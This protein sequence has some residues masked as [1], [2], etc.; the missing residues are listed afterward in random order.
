MADEYLTAALYGMKRF[1]EWASKKVK[2]L[3]WMEKLIELLNE[4]ETPHSWI[5]FKSYD[6]YDGT[7][8]W[9]DIDG[10]TE[11]AWSDSFICG[12]RF[13]WVE[14]L[15]END[16]IDRDKNVL[17][18][19]FSSVYTYEGEDYEEHLKECKLLMLLSIQDNPIEFLVSI[20]K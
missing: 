17:A 13:W 4:Y 1:N 3:M 11:I 6:N 15:V 16:K 7:F 18:F 10:E 9:V 14:W 12:K 2:E 8:Y 5:V 20:L 19:E